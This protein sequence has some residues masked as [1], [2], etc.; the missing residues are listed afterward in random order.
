MRDT[1]K[2]EFEW[3]RPLPR[4]RSGCVINCKEVGYED[5]TWIQIDQEKG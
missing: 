3:K 1:Y 5:V 2:F 4:H